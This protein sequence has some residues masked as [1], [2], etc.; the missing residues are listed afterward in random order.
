MNIS[1]ETTENEMRLTLNISICLN[2]KL[3]YNL[4]RSKQLE[5]FATSYVLLLLKKLLLYIY[6]IYT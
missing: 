3:N 1:L 6:Y 2:K 4:L 5:P